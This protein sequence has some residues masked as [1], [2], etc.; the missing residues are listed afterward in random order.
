M[1]A[2][3][4][5]LAVIVAMLWAWQA[6]GAPPSART[7]SSSNPASAA[8]PSGPTRPEP[9]AHV[10]AP[11][12]PIEL[13]N[14]TVGLQQSVVRWKIPDQSNG[15]VIQQWLVR[16]CPKVDGSPYAA[17]Q[18]V[19]Q[20][21]GPNGQSSGTYVQAQIPAH[22]MFMGANAP[23]NGA[24]ICSV[25]S[26]GTSCADRI[27]VRFTN[28]GIAPAPTKLQGAAPSGMP[29]GTTGIRTAPSGGIAAKALGP[30]ATGP[31]SPEQVQSARLGGSPASG[32]LAKKPAAAVL[33]QTIH[34]PQITADGNGVALSLSVIPGLVH[35]SSISA[36]GTGVALSS[37]IIP[38]LVH[39]SPIT[40][41]GTGRLASIAVRPSLQLKQ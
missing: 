12:K 38:G 7:P 30:Q 26:A 22:V 6:F 41:D 23:V 21:S 18:Q 35:T 14:P 40:A 34:T 32:A 25:N 31:Q 11:Y 27:A 2:H 20:L 1:N 33:M 5:N 8:V 17:C 39:T 16:A 19:Q 15:R 24:E 13:S 3:R 29:S 4:R 36:D 37:S 10:A 28:P 9:P